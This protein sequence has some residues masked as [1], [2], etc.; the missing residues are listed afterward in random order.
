M[1]AALIGGMDRLKRDY[2]NA[3]LASGVDLKVFT[4]KENRIADKL[5]Q[6]DLVIVFTNKISHAAKR[7]VVQHAKANSIP[8]QMLHSCGVSTLRQAL[9]TTN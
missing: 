8:V 3:A 2:I 9:E 5:G 4:G 6:A 7:E 1:C